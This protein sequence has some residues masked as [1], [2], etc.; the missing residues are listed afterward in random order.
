MKRFWKHILFGFGCYMVFLFILWPASWLVPRQG[1]A[2]LYFTGV[3]G[4]VWSGQVQ[5]LVWRG[6]PLG[7]VHWRFALGALL[8]GHL[9]AWIELH[10]EDVALQGVGSGN[11]MGHGVELRD[12][13][14]QRLAPE[15]A[16]RLGLPWQLA[17]SIR[18]HID[19]AR[20]QPRAV[21][22]LTGTWLWSQAA[23]LSPVAFRLGKV[24]LRA[25]SVGQHEDI[26]ATFQGGDLA[27]TGSLI[28]GPGWRYILKL[29]ISTA[30]A[31]VQ[32]MLRW[33]S[34][35]DA[36]GHWVL[37]KRGDLQELGTWLGV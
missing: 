28:L 13:D 25:A 31:R 23:V 24:H 6:L 18:G 32:P 10:G 15:L 34:Q 37:K 35:P 5:T 1:L 17:G 12:V 14:I 33:L 7:Q 2:G 26:E 4:T 3:S 20:W 9:G 29:N 16:Q 11:I 21:P 30:D 27:G 19:F 22:E 36:A 8:R